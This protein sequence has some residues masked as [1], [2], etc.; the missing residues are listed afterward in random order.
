M[1]KKNGVYIIRNIPCVIHKC[2]D[3]IVCAYCVYF[4]SKR[5]STASW[6]SRKT[7]KCPF[8]NDYC[9]LPIGEGV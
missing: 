8:P 7:K 6:C 4:T 1:Y 2:T 9:A 3:D 5:K